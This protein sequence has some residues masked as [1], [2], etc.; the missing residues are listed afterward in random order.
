[1]FIRKPTTKILF[2]WKN[3]TNCNPNVIKY[4][5]VIVYSQANHEKNFLN[6]KTVKIATQMLSS[7]LMF[8]STT[9]CLGNIS[10]VLSY[11]KSVLQEE[12]YDKLA[13]ISYYFFNFEK[14]MFWP[15]ISIPVLWHYIIRLMLPQNTPTKI[16][17]WQNYIVKIISK[18]LVKK[19]KLT[20]CILNVIF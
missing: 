16:Q 4:Y 6:R 10:S 1:M 17:I 12:F 9:I 5:Q 13:I 20:F 2:E 11:K 19:T 8:P 7:T 14:C 18:V 3:G 15:N